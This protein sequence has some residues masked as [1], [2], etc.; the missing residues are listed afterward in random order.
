MNKFARLA[1][2]PWLLI[3]TT[4]G[5]ANAVDEFGW[6]EGSWERP[7]GDLTAVEEWTRVSP[8]TMEGI[9][10]LT[11]GNDRRVTEHLRIE[12]FG[13]RIYY[14][15][16]PVENELPTPFELVESK[17]GRWM[18]ENSGY[19]FPQRLIYAPTDGGGLTVRV[20]GPNED[21]DRG[22]DLRFERRP[23]GP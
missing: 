6:L 9:A 4:S 16:L 12:R 21:G 13:D 17:D 11:D 8:N 23:P 15:A 1:T 19:D 7:A 14:L 2:L 3:L 18:F 20:E 5:Q 10:Y 22:F